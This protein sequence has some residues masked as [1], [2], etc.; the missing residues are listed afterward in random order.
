MITILNGNSFGW[1]GLAGKPWLEP[2]RQLVYCGR[3]HQR[4]RLSQS[5]VS[6][7]HTMQWD[8]VNNR[9]VPGERERV[10]EVFRIQYRTE[11]A[12]WRDGKESSKLVEGTIEI[13][14]LYQEISKVDLVC[15]CVPKQCHCQYI[16]KAIPWVINRLG[17]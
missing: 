3:S 4:K 1:V 2:R 17:S 9:Y 16:A 12:V 11:L 5:L 14:R 7:P 13:A 8:A 6:N 10:N 15:H